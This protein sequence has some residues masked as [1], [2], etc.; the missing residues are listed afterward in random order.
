MPSSASPSF[1]KTVCRFASGAGM[2][3]SAPVTGIRTVGGACGGG[4][5]GSVGTGVDVPGS[6]VSD[7]TGVTGVLVGVAVGSSGGVVGVLVGVAG[8]TSGGVVGGWGG[9]A[10][11]G[12]GVAP[13]GFWGEFR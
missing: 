3:R 13:W 1:P 11:S 2:D 10:G 9:E 8:G 6:T 5:G 4:G 7:T 12:W